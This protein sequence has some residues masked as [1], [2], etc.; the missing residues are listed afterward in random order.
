MKKQYSRTIELTEQELIIIRQ[1]VR[2]FGYTPSKN[3]IE[4]KELFGKELSSVDIK[5]TTAVADI[6][7]EDNLLT[8]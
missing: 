4:M 5:M 8:I 3:D 2:S 1:A 6:F 7:D